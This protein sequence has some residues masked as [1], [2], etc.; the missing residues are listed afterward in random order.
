MPWA[1]ALAPG[2]LLAVTLL[3]PAGAHAQ[4]PTFSISIQNDS[5]FRRNW[6]FCPAGM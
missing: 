3:F 6:T 1:G 2:W 5:S 4:N